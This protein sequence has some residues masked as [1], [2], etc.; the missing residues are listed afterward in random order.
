MQ[1]ARLIAIGYIV[2]CGLLIAAV[3][4]GI[5]NANAPLAVFTPGPTAVPNPAETVMLDLVYSTEKDDWL[6]GAVQQWQATN[7][8]VDGRPVQVTLR[9]EGSQ[10]IVSGLEDGSLKPTIVSPA[11]SLQI[12]QI[13][14]ATIDG[15]QNSAADTQPLLYTPLVIVA[16]QSDR[17]G[18]PLNNLKGDSSL[19]PTI[20]EQ[21]QS[22]QR[23]FLFGQTAPDVSNSGLQTMVLMAYAYHNKTSDL[24]VADVQDAGFQQWYRDYA[25]NVARFGASTGTF[26]EDMVRFGPSRYGAIA[27]YESSALERIKAAENRWGTIRIIYPPVNTWSDHPFAIL[28]TTWTT[29]LQRQAAAQLREFLLSQPQQQAAVNY[30][31]RPTDPDVRID[32]AD[33]AF[34]LN[35]QYGVDKDFRATLVEPSA[36]VIDALLQFW[37]SDIQATVKR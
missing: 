11:S 12:R 2:L 19:W 35:Q 5:I 4:G 3:T 21:V 20:Q 30:G 17:A 27:V 13:N 32:T 18:D 26:M 10:A 34:T 22:G 37:R 9:G 15:K 6:K 29:P 31:F 28:D 24:T 25:R 7:P 8:T 23:D 33:S 14:A 16:W 1:K 36:E